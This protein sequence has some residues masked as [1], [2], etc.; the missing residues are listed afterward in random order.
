MQITVPSYEG[1][2]E[3]RLSQKGVLVDQVPSPMKREEKPDLPACNAIMNL[4]QDSKVSILKTSKRG[5][6]IAV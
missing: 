1:A 2:D 3:G 6:L 4:T 5:L